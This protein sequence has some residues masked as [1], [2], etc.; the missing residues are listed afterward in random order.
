[1][2]TPGRTTRDRVGSAWPESNRTGRL[3][4]DSAERD[5][6]AIQAS[7]PSGAAAGWLALAAVAPAAALPLR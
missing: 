3:G 7:P 6:P 2:Q 4:M 5:P 1:M